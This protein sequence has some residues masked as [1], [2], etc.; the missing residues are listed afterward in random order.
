MDL[1]EAVENKAQTDGTIQ[2]P[3][4]TAS[5]LTLLS[6]RKA[7]FNPNQDITGTTHLPLPTLKIK[8]QECSSK[9][10]MNKRILKKK[11]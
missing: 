11:E 10:K 5:I 2:K 4:S 9:L 6:N 1:I 8:V 7:S 3:G